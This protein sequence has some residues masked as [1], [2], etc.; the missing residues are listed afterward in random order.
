MLALP[1]HAHR[2]PARQPGRHRA[3]RPSSLVA[4]TGLRTATVAI[5]LAACALTA[6]PAAADQGDPASAPPAAVTDLATGSRAASDAASAD[7]DGAYA[8]HEAPGVEQ[9]AA[10]VRRSPGARSR[11][12]KR[13]HVRHS[14]RAAARAKVLSPAAQR[15]AFGS[16]VLAEARRHLGAP[17]VYGASGPWAFDC[18]GFT[19]Y[20]YR[21]V[22]VSLPRTSY[23]QYTAVQHIPAGAAV[24]GDLIFLDGLGHVAIYAGDGMMYDAPTSGSSVGLRPIYGGFLAGRVSG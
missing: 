17:Y 6:G 9:V 2:A 7:P 14:P 4:R 24:P 11:E 20:V 23:S 12:E 13:T 8:V 21:Q 22:G 16:S 15:A 10:P 18:S 5:A 1:R 19:S 3:S